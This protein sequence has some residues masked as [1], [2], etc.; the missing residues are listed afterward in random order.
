MDLQSGIIRTVWMLVETA[1]P[2]LLLEL[3]NRELVQKLIAETERVF[4]ISYQERQ[5][6]S[7][8]INSKTSLI[9]DLAYCKV[10]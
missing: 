4:S 1:N 9:R 2:Y 10:D 8:Y 6:L 3:S 7:R 5:T